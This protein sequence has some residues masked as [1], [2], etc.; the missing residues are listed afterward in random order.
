[1]VG[2]Q[3]KKMVTLSIIFKK[4]RSAKPPVPMGLLSANLSAGLDTW[5]P[6]FFLQSMNILIHKAF[7]TDTQTSAAAAANRSRQACRT[8]L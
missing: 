2:K 6:C 3:K 5:A 4:E 1:M 7:S 8:C